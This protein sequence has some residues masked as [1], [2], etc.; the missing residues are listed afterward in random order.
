M[1]KQLV[2]QKRVRYNGK[3]MRYSMNQSDDCSESESAGNERTN[4]KKKRKR[5]KSKKKRKRRRKSTSSDEESDSDTEYSKKKMQRAPAWS[6]YDDQLLLKSVKYDVAKNKFPKAKDFRA[7]HAKF[8]RK[9]DYKWR[10]A[11]ALHQHFDILI[12]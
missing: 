7:I 9:A 5:K 8:K 6:K 10:S 11:E 3:K 1:G 12:G 2:E 4:K